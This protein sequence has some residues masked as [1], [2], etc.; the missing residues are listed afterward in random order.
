MSEFNLCDLAENGYRV[1]SKVRRDLEGSE[2]NIPLG[3]GDRVR[4]H[5]GSYNESLGSGKEYRSGH[6]IFKSEMIIIQKNCKNLYED[7]FGNIINRDI[8]LYSSKL[9]RKIAT[10]MDFVELWE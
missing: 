1:L 2:F 10:C 9:K 8:V 3:L 5:D 7:E 6:K 4:V